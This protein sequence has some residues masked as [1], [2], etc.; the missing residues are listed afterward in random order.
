MKESLRENF[1]EY[2]KQFYHLSPESL[3]VL[4]SLFKPIK[5]NK[6]EFIIKEGEKASKIAF[7]NNGLVR[8]FF[9]NEKGEEF[10]KI[11]LKSPSLVAAYSSLLTNKTNKIN[12]Q[13]LTDCL[14]FEVDYNKLT[15]LYDTYRDIESLNRKIVEWFFVEM[16]KRQMSL[17]M[18]NAKERYEVFKKDFPEYENHIQQYHIAS[19][20]GITPTQLS[21]IR[22]TRN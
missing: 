20:L 16:E 17:I 5:R 18:Y 6:N 3:E 4:L 10:N 15:S 9:Q 2:L 21:R 14:F 1:S 8:L 12:I 22:S 11:L 13:C 7:L 19:Y